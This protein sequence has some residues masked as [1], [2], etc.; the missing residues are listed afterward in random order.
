MDLQRFCESEV[1]AMEE[2][3]L[4]I[5]RKGKYMEENEKAMQELIKNASEIYEKNKAL[6]DEKRKKGELFNTFNVIGLWSEEV[7]LHSAFIAE[8]LNP[9]GS[10]G[11]DSKFLAKFCEKFCDDFEFDC[12]NANLAVEKA[13]DDGRIDILVEQSDGKKAIVI[14]NKI[15]AGDQPSQLLRYK[16]FCEKKFGD[17]NG[18]NNWKMFYL[19]LDGH[20]PSEDSAG[21]KNV[22]K[23]DVYWQ[24]IS[25]KNDIVSWLDACKEISGDKNL[26]KASIE[27]YRDLIKQITNNDLEDE[28]ANEMVKLLEEGDN[29]ILAEKMAGQ[30]EETKFDILKNQIFPALKEK[31]GITD[32]DFGETFGE[33]YS[34]FSVKNKKWGDLYICFQFDSSKY[35]DFYSAILSEG[36]T[37]DNVKKFI[38][39]HCSGNEEQNK[40]CLLWDYMSDYRDWDTQTFCN[41]VNNIDKF[42]NAI[43]ERVTRYSKIIE[44]A[45]THQ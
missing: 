32:F 13:F 11:C 29:L 9:N 39:G 31:C 38:K 20:D 16:E 7:R 43:N 1:A 26:V 12:K 37:T 21:E 22:G 34:S 2:K 5:V 24:N 14:E 44:S 30:I 17:G 42:C 19:T 18:D 6:K 4:A 27:Q 10:H 23:N 45:L 33:K 36:K 15:Y 40:Y 35:R 25:Y 8:L 3:I 28:M 41:I